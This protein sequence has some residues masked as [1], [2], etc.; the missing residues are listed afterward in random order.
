MALQG[1]LDT[2]ALPD[3]LRLLAGSAKSG[4]LELEGDRGSGVA[5]L[6]DGG[7]VGGDVQAAP[8]ATDPVDLIF[9]LLRF[10][11]GTFRFDGDSPV[12]RHG[13]PF[14]VEMLLARAG[15][16]LIEWHE[17][18][19]VMPS[20]DAWLTLAEDLASDEIIVS[21]HDWRILAAVGGGLSA[22]QLA[23]R[24][25]LTELGV[26]CVVRDLVESATLVVNEARSDAI[27]DSD[28]FTPQPKEAPAR[29]RLDALA[30]SFSPDD[31]ID[32]PAATMLPEPLPGQGTSFDGAGVASRRE[33]AAAMAP[34]ESTQPEGADDHP[35][36]DR[37]S[38]VRFLSSVKD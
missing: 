21:R 31:H 32:A 26:Y 33:P 4:R 13:S 27:A 10:N 24:L 6:Y 29:A 9:E 38:I 34:I 19:V 17:V 35:S 8:N 22:R 36:G 5:L 3:L 14:D 23:D 30:A 37:G 2:L 25:D 28:D 7:V 15:E 12:T 11:E 18:E 16:M 1:D 20:L